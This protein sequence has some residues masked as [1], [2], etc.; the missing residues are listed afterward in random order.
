MSFLRVSW[1]FSKIQSLCLVAAFDGWPGPR[2]VVLSPEVFS[3][4]LE[5]GSSS[6]CNSRFLAARRFFS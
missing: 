6:I 4:A 5:M 2:L 3:S 1:G